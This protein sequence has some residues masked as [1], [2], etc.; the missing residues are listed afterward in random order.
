MTQDYDADVLVVGAGPSGLALATE[1][2]M[3][4]IRV[5]VVERNDRTG[6]QPRAKTTNVRSMAQMRRWGL[7]GQVRAR[8]PLTPDFPRQVSFRT[9]L[10]DPPI[11]L[12]H[13]AF[14]ATPGRRDA[15]PEH[16]EFIPQYVIEGILA[17]HVAAHPDARLCFGHR[18][19]GFTQ[20]ETGVT[21][22]IEGPGGPA[23]LRSRYLVGADGGRSRIRAALRIEME[24]QSDMLTFATL[25]LRIPGLDAEPGLV[26]AL[27]HWIIDAEAASFIGPLDH[28]DLWYW[29]KL[30]PRDTPTETLLGHVR[31][32]IGREMPME[33][34]T[35]DDWV[36]NSLM[37]ARYREGR[38]FLVGDACHLH[39]PFGGHGMNLGIGDGV[40]LGWK[41]AAAIE[42]WGSEALL[43]SYQN[44]RRG[45]HA[46]V[47]DSATRNVASLS[48]HFVDPAL[49]DPGPAGAAARAATARAVERLK[50]P[51]FRSLGLVLG[52]R[53]PPSGAVAAEPGAAPPLEVTHYLPTA[54]PG[55]LAPH[56][57][58][59]DGQ[60]LYDLFGTGFTLLVTGPARDPAGEAALQAEAARRGV[61]LAL[62][63][64]GID[65]LRALYEANFALIRP[66]QHVA[67]RGDTLPAAG[68][69][70]ALMRG[71]ARDGTSEAA[72]AP[73]GRI[74]TA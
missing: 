15:F 27:F 28:G 71:L 35:R 10:F 72:A 7:A 3:R 45:V 4:G 2:L 16:A 48:D 29:S 20:D 36:V 69:L 33:V 30:T 32:A 43:D 62:A 53:Y 24:G 21:A 11:H 44:E 22:E 65:G 37:A 46:A 17:D 58:G 51:E 18:L 63:A 9:G 52:Y 8:S 50:T 54:R 19:T 70:V 60:S 31:R 59:A 41:L 49:A 23:R 61:P 25:I 73:D 74:L 56:A 38:V 67:W 26:P 40:D 34:V 64:P 66:D 55:H 42:G 14:C 68:A 13:D 47:I 12:F 5:I 1:L 6:L 39:S 57:W